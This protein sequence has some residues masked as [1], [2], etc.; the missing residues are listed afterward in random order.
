MMNRQTIALG[1]MTLL[2][3]ACAAP[4]PAPTDGTKVA[5]AAKPECDKE[6]RVGSMMP[7]KDCSPP[8]SEEE[9]A[10]MRAEMANRVRS[11]GSAPPG[12]GS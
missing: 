8:M 12:A 9:K 7:K 6:Y 11:A 10:R 3:A 2:L 5:Q 1:L 4:A